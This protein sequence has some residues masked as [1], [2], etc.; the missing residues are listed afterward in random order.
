MAAIYSN[1]M[2]KLYEPV[3]S[4][5]F[6]IV[7]L[8][9]IKS[10][11]DVQELKMAETSQ[12]DLIYK[13]KLQH[14]KDSSIIYSQKV[15]INNGKLK[16]DSLISNYN[17]KEI[18]KIVTK[19]IIKVKFKIADPIKI[20]SANYIKL[21]IEFNHKEKWVS[22]KGSIDTLASLNIDSITTFSTYTY[23]VVDT[24]RAGLINKILNK[25]DLVVRLHID[26]PN[27]KLINMG[28][29][30]MREQS[31]W[32]QSTAFKM[33]IGAI[34]GGLIIFNVK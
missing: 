5:I 8:S 31:P 13:Y 29:A 26:N 17:P 11:R 32:Y 3:L 22:I 15:N 16:V 2:K 34:L 28:H 14:L 20:D 1:I 25:K 7:V 10:C 33:G 4:I 30:Y 27:I 6:I 9:L 24:L 21:P 19:T 23:G 18:V 12:N